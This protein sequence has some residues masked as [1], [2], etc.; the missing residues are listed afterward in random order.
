MGLAPTVPTEGVNPQTL[1]LGDRW[2]PSPVQ[3]I[4]LDVGCNL[5]LPLVAVVEQLLLVVE[6]LLV[7]LRRELKV[8][9]LPGWDGVTLEGHPGGKGESPQSPQSPLTSTMAS[10]GQAS[11][12]NPQ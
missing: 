1:Y 6:Q 2:G 5:G 12:Q 8:G 11:W 9:A 10:T 7:R 4:G 3:V